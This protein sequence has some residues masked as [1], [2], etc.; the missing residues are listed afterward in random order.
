MGDSHHG[1]IYLSIHT[2]TNI[3]TFYKIIFWALILRMKYKI[4]MNS[5]NEFSHLYITSYS[6][7]Q[8]YFKR[9]KNILFPSYD[10]LKQLFIKLHKNNHSYLGTIIT[11][12]RLWG[13]MQLCSMYSMTVTLRSGNSRKSN[14]SKSSAA[15]GSKTS[16]WG[17]QLEPVLHSPVH[18]KTFP[19]RNECLKCSA[20]VNGWI[21]YSRLAEMTRPYLT[22]LIL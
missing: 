6:I 9:A 19:C 1:S 10:L 11:C 12:Y 7:V 18:R 17:K 22:H 16:Q 5:H 3:Y 2:H 15:C 4:S 21:S 20:V 14:T 13:L 8:L